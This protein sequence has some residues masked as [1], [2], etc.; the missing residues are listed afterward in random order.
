MGHILDRD[1]MALAFMRSASV[2]QMIGYTVETWYGYAGWGLLD[3]FLEQPGRFTLAE[4]FFSN[5][6]ALIHK[7]TQIVT[8]QDQSSS[9][10]HDKMGLEFDR[11]VVAFY[12]DPSLEARMAASTINW[13]QTVTFDESTH[14]FT[15]VIEPCF[16]SKTFLPVNTNGSQRGYRPLTVLLPHRINVKTV[17]FLDEFEL[18]VALSSLAVIIPVEG[19]N[20]QEKTCLTFR[21]QPF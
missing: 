13:N 20:S 19:L 14:S 21:A 6:N 1:C 18:N 9:R 8:S 16:G 11:D 7:L 4:A 15:I 5:C 17:K 10:L 12:G 3:Y 2:M